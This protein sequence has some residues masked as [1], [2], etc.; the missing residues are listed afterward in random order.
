MLTSTETVRRRSQIFRSDAGIHR[1]STSLGRTKFP[2]GRKVGYCCDDRVA[3]T[4][5]A[6]FL[7][8]TGRRIAPPFSASDLHRPNCS[9]N[10]GVENAKP[11]CSERAAR[12]FSLS[13]YPTIRPKAEFW[14][15]PGL[16]PFA[17]RGGSRASVFRGNP[18]DNPAGVSPDDPPKIALTRAEDHTHS[19]P[20]NLLDDLVV[21]EMPLGVFIRFGRGVCLDSR[22]HSIHLRSARLGANTGGKVRSSHGTRFDNA[23]TRSVGA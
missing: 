11:V 5:G 10:N 15:Y 13:G 8:A 18:R 12:F 16:R 17:F 6:C 23:G 9:W 21:P 19:A 1:Q 2:R 14:G 3:V 20:P 7:H 4:C 22:S